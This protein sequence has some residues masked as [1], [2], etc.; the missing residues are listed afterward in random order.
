MYPD[1]FLNRYEVNVNQRGE[2]ECWLW[3]G[4]TNSSGYGQ[5]QLD[6][7]KILAHRVSYTISHGPIPD[8]YHVDHICMVK[9]CVNPKH[10]RLASPKQNMEHRLPY[11]NSSTG[12]RGVRW[13]VQRGKY[14]AQVTHR[15]KTIHVGTFSDLAEAEKAVIAKRNELF[16]HN[17]MD[18]V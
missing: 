5:I 9:L 14:R 12:V 17:D 3:S 8:G 18:R 1:E 7:K 6:R 15:C 11:R 4:Y 13:D 2:D 16:T 10:L